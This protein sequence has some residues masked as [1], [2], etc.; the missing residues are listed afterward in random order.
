M[1]A[2]TASTTVGRADGF[3]P[4]FVDL[5]T[6]PLLPNRRIGRVGTEERAD[7]GKA[8]TAFAVLANMPRA[9][10]KQRIGHT[11]YILLG[12]EHHH[13]HLTAIR[14]SSQRHNLRESEATS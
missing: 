3:Q 13:L 4:P 5:F 10:S 8:K 7:A 12:H 14:G 11:V 1:A 9:G 2:T 6:L